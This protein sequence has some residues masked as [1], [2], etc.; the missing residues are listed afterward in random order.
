MNAV[1]KV[2]D[3]DGRITI[4][5]EMRE[6]AGLEA[7]GIVRLTVT[8]C[9]L[10]VRKVALLEIGNQ[11]PEMVEAYLEAAFRTIGKEKQLQMAAQLLKLAGREEDSCGKT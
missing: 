1:Y 2:I 8:H 11:E 10:A 4:P 3:K 6:T 7:G 5:R 9:G